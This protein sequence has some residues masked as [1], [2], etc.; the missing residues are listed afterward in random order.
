MEIEVGLIHDVL[1][2]NVNFDVLGHKHTLS[3]SLVFGKKSESVSCSVPSNSLRP[4]GLQP[5]RFLYPWNSPGE[6][7]RMGSHSLLLGIF[8]TQRSTLRADSFPS[9]PLSSLL[10]SVSQL[11]EHVKRP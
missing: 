7:T 1:H 2:L 6:N 11:S 3:E 4:H 8:P 5:T 10:H 9:E